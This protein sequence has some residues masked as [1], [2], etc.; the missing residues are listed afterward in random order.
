MNK[1][2]ISAAIGVAVGGG[3][4][5][6]PYFGAHIPLPTMMAAAAALSMGAAMAVLTRS[7]L[8]KPVHHTLHANLSAVRLKKLH[9]LIEKFP[10]GGK[11]LS[12]SIRPETKAETLDVVKRPGQYAKQDIVLALRASGSTSFNP[13]ELKKLFLA[14]R[15]Q[16]G[17]VHLILRDK[18]D[19]F[20]GY[21]P[22]FSAKRE[23][24]GP[25]AE[26]A[27]AR[28]IVE[29]FADPSLSANLRLIGGAS[30]TDT[31]SDEDRVS[32]AIERM[33]G[34]FLTLVVLDGGNHRLP[35]GLLNF[36]SLM[37]HTV[38]AQIGHH[39]DGHA[40]AHHAGHSLGAFRPTK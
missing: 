29:V 13:F 2:A 28:Y 16:M 4:M 18:H 31:I 14:L 36:N 3:A 7:V 35:I 8:D 33:T 38:G 10:E 39:G 20:V 12:L 5:A 32:Q 6:A 22:G 21:I 23:F 37:G 25:G 19:E 34:G 1:V 24:T 26:G 30:K 15:D 27:I 9:G 17:F 11:V 40:G